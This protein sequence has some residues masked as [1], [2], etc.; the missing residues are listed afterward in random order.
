MTWQR[1]DRYHEQAGPF[2][3]SAAKV[4]TG[5]RFSAWRSTADGWELIGV[6]ETAAEAR[7]LCK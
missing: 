5:W 7:G 4:P 2:R 1:I 6:R 3:V